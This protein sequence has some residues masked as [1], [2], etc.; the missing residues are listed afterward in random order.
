MTWGYLGAALV[1]VVSSVVIIAIAVYEIGW[2]WQ[3]F[4]DR[5]EQSEKGEP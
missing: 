5:I 3:S 1:M 2:G 4:E